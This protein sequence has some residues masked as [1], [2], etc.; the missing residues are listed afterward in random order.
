MCQFGIVLFQAQHRGPV[1]VFPIWLHISG[2]VFLHAG[3]KEDT[4]CKGWWCYPAWLGVCVVAGWSVFFPLFSVLQLKR[5]LLLLFHQWEDCQTEATFPKCVWFLFIYMVTPF[6]VSQG[7]GVLEMPS[8]T[9]KTISLLS[10]IVAYQR[11]SLAVHAC[12][13]LCFEHVLEWVM[14][15]CGFPSVLVSRMWWYVFLS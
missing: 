3:A 5:S 4:G 9:G 8:G 2:A 13:L 11:V 10:L 14:A 15:C 12:G 7:H 1:G 6:C